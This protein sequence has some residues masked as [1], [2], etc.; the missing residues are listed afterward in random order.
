MNYDREAALERSKELDEIRRIENRKK[1][2]TAAILTIPAFGLVV[3]YYLGF[4]WVV[5]FVRGLADGHVFNW[6]AFVSFFAV[7]WIVV[8]LLWR[9]VFV[10]AAMQTTWQK[11]KAATPEFDQKRPDA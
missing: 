10:W 4:G 2:I 3:L 6:T 5:N 11:I 1:D 7:L 8:R 9:L